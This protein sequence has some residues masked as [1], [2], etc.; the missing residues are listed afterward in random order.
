MFSYIAKSHKV[1]AYTLSTVYKV[2][3]ARVLINT[4]TRRMRIVI[5]LTIK[6][7]EAA[8]VDLD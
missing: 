6:E 1:Q 8:R 3:I 2:L 5:K 7:N 4:R